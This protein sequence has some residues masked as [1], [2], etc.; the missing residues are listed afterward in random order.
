M[1]PLEQIVIV[2]IGVALAVYTWVHADI[3]AGAHAHLELHDTWWS[4]LSQCAY[5]LL[6]WVTPLSVGALLLAREDLPDSELWQILAWCLLGLLSWLVC[7]VAAIF[8]AAIAYELLDRLDFAD[9]QAGHDP[10][11]SAEESEIFKYPEEEQP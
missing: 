10:P 5:C 8:V 2:G 1:L 9:Q 3:F 6:H 11:L 7:S 4:Y